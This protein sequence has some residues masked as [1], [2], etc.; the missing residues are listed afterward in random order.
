[1]KQWFSPYYAIVYVTQFDKYLP[2][3]IFFL[4]KQFLR[5]SSKVTLVFKVVVID[6]LWIANHVIAK[7]IDGYK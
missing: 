7:F 6:G 1:M 4:E 2:S 3:V 5:K